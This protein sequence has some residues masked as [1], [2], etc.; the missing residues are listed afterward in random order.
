LAI[1]AALSVACSA[2]S[3]DDGGTSSAIAQ[4]ESFDSDYLVFGNRDEAL[5]WFATMRPLMATVGIP[6][7][8]DVLP[9]DHPDTVRVRALV[10]KHWRAIVPRFSPH[11]PFPQILV[12]DAPIAN[13]F[14]VYDRAAG[15]TADAVTVSRPLLAM[16]DDHADAIIAHELGHLILKNVDPTF[17]ER[18]SRF[19]AVSGN[20]PLGITQTDDPSVRSVVATW[21][22]DAGSLGPY[23]LE[24]LN[25]LP[26][27]GLLGV[28]LNL[29]GAAHFDA[30]N[31]ACVAVMAGKNTA[32]NTLASGIALDDMKLTLKAEQLATIDTASKSAVQNAHDCFLPQPGSSLVDALA[33]AFGA[34]AAALEATFLPEELAALKGSTDAID[35]F[36]QL[37]HFMSQRMLATQSTDRFDTF[38]VYSNEEQAD[39]FSMTV[40]ALEGQEPAAIGEAMMAFLPV[41]AQDACKAKLAQGQVPNY[42][43]ADPHH[44]NCYRLFH[45]RAFAKHLQSGGTGVTAK[46]IPAPI[47]AS[48]KR[49]VNPLRDRIVVD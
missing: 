36:F 11:I 7:T 34:P 35:A 26:L 8:R 1:L 38:R 13:A 22:R 18:M 30:A 14:V 43:L 41:Q 17:D 4:T 19:Y 29:H 23:M 49:A 48:E 39:D 32:F 20:E 12:I 3:D 42:M 28:F 31:P 45:A 9:V 5:A 33:A 40:R 44:S 15:K 47:K 46:D 16:S 37:T 2:P 24:E 10:E 21:M 6:T 27:G 25:D